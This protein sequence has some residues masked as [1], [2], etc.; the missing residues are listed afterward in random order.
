M[1]WSTGLPISGEG[2]LGSLGCDCE[3]RRPQLPPRSIGS[4]THLQLAPDSRAG[5]RITTIRLPKHGIA[6]SSACGPGVGST[7]VDLPDCTGI[8]SGSANGRS[9]SQPNGLQTRRN[10][11]YSVSIDNRVALTL[12]D[13]PMI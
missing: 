7:S 12:A 10:Q 6:S 3:P 2:C 11:C 8:V 5:A 1:T 9:C 13:A 4:S